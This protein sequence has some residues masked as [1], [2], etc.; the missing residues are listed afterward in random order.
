MEQEGSYMEESSES[1]ESV[2]SEDNSWEKASTSSDIDVEYERTDTSSSVLNSSAK[3]TVR[4]RRG[5][6]TIVGGA[7]KLFT[8]QSSKNIITNDS[9]TGETENKPINNGKRNKKREVGPGKEKKPRYLWENTNLWIYGDTQLST[10]HAKQSFADWFFEA[11]SDDF[12]K[13]LVERTYEY[14]KKVENT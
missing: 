12:I 3:G 11:F 13:I 8:R 4:R 2:T 7:R 10:W 9:T 1:I 14:A 6:R 5:L